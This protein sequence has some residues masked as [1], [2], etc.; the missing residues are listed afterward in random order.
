MSN[1]SQDHINKYSRRDFI[2]FSAAAGAAL[3]GLGLSGCTNIFLRNLRAVKTPAIETVRV[4]FVG[5]GGRGTALCKN[6]LKIEGVQLKALCD[7]VK[8]KVERMQKMAVEAGQPKPA[9]YI[10]G[11]TD[12]KRLCESE[13]LDLVITATPWQLHTPVCV[14]AM[15]NGK[16]SA[17]EV[18]AALSVD[19]CWQLVETAE[20]Y[21]RHCMILENVCYFRNVL[22]V[23]RMLREGLLG[24]IAHCEAGYQHDRRNSHF[25]S[26]G[27]MRWRTEHYIN[28]NGNPYPTHPI[29]P[30]ANWM[31]IN[32]GDKFDHLVS[33][34]SKSMALNDFAAEHFGKDHKLA[35]QRFALGDV[36][37]SLI[38][39]A[40]GRTVTLYH[41]TQLPRPYDLIFRVQ[42]TKGI[43]SGTLNKIYIEGKSPKRHAWEP[44]EKYSSK[45]DHP[46]WKNL[47]ER[48]KGG[49]HGGADFIEL[50][51]L[52]K[53]LQTGAPLDID[54]YDAATWS[55][56]TELT[57]R[58]VTGKSKA[59]DFPDFTRGAWKSREPVI[60]TPF[61]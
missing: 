35:K 25:S 53:A 61:T 19:E 55:V 7:I 16:H 31:D 2:K 51:R 33:M 38:K 27:T 47:A 28:R 3:S 6:L 44:I 29:G 8:E 24:E 15:K 17:T 60:F 48:A 49:G 20:K 57:H 1:N 56:I 30:I 26:N 46:I 9:A 22:M 10:R 4:G 11:D 14:S 18:P 37:V 50:Y 21:N 43:Y 59:I 54:V 36:N 58:S 34:S 45:Y 52:I 5:V 41:D 13:D 32:R 23:Q 12:Y 40:K 39:T 42:G